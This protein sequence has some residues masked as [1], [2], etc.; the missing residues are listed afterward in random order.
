MAAEHRHVAID[1]YAYLSRMARW[2][3]GYK[4]GFS[5]SVI[6]LLLLADR[7][8]VSLCTLVFMAV[9]TVCIGKIPLGD[10]GRLL[11]VPLAFILMGSL[12]IAV[13]FGTDG[14]GEWNLQFGS[15]YFFL[16]K[17]SLNLAL[18]TG[19]KALAAVS[20]LYMM[21]LSTPMGEI[22]AVFEKLHVPGILL[23]LMHLIYRYIFILSEIHHSQ[24]EAAEARLGTSCFRIALRTFSSEAATLLILSLKKAGAYYDA[25]EARGYDGSLVM[26]QEKKK[27]TL[28]QFCWGAGYCLL[29]GLVLG[30]EQLSGG[31][32]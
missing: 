30:M 27:L 9:L 21:T 19:F 14:M 3:G 32:W 5:V 13:E 16:T 18:T 28:G 10:Y 31:R 23:E 24:Q 22:I 29:V 1:Y 20:A 6:C 2:N 12:A 8:S 4:V 25:M 26:L 11:K 17:E 15:I 7:I